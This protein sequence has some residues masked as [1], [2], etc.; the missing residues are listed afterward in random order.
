MK[1]FLDLNKSTT[2]KELKTNLIS[3]KIDKILFMVADLFM[4]ELYEDLIEIIIEFYSKYIHNANPMLCILINKKLQLFKEH[5]NNISDIR[6]IKKDPVMRQLFCQLFSLMYYSKKDNPVLI[7]KLEKDAFDLLNFKETLKAENINYIVNFVMEGDP[8]DLFIQLNEFSYN[9]SINNYSTSCYWYEMIVEYYAY[10]KKQKNILNYSIR[11]ELLDYIQV[12]NTSID[13]HIIWSILDIL[14]FYCKNKSEQYNKIFLCC[15]QIF[16]IK[17]SLGS[18]KK[19]KT[20]IYFIIYIITN[21]IDFDKEILTKD[22]INKIKEL[23]NDV[24][25]VY[26]KILTLHNEQTGIKKETSTVKTRKVDVVV[27][28]KID[29]LK[30]I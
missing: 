14:W 13:G 25:N 11:R 23:L 8:I 2:I 12:S 18:I 6:L 20:L 19:R 24:P 16:C 3:G 9:I 28:K 10:C 15:C 29:F 22:S 5:I 4:A 27:D 1:T 21:N 30:S 26:A 17:L 7:Q